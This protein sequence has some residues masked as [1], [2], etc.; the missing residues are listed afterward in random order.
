ML[1]F[2]YYQ[3]PIPYTSATREHLNES[4]QARNWSQQPAASSQQPE[5]R[6][7]KKCFYK[8]EMLQATRAY[9]FPIPYT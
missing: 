3:I 4:S 6:S 1:F 7:Q 2:L 5:G 9:N 8:Y